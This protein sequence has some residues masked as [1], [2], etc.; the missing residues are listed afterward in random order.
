MC[1]ERQ[2]SEL[3]SYILVATD[4]ENPLY[5]PVAEERLFVEPFKIPDYWARGWSMDVGWNRTAGLV[6]A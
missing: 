6:G 1:R 2:V 4:P 3:A 5:H